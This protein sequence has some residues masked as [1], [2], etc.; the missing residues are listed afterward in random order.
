MT[1]RTEDFLSGDC[2]DSLKL[3]DYGSHD[4]RVYR[5]ELDGGNARCVFFYKLG[6]SHK[7]AY[8]SR[9]DTSDLVA[10]EYLSGAWAG[11]RA[12]RRAMGLRDPISCTT[13]EYAADPYDFSVE[14]I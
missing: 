12:C 8:I 3:L 14:E 13:Q 5:G 11:L 1:E 9:I 7:V 6:P 4:L 2:L 10:L